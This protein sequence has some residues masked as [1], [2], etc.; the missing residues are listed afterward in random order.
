MKKNIIILMSTLICGTMFSQVGVNTPNPQGVFNVDG[1]KDNPL[2]GNGHTA[3]QQ[4]NDVTVLANGNVGLGTINPSAKLEV[5]TGGTASNPVP[6]FKLVD[7]T[8]AAGSILMSDANGVGTWQPYSI[9]KGVV[10][11]TIDGAG[12]TVKSTDAATAAPLPGRTAALYTMYQITLTKGS[13]I[14]NMGLTL[15]NT[16]YPVNIGAGTWVHGYISSDKTRWDVT[17]FTQ[18]GPAGGV[19]GYASTV[20]KNST[21]N[22]PNFFSGT[23]TVNVPQTITLYLLLEKINN[24]GGG[25]NG[26]IWEHNTARTGNYFYAI[27]SSN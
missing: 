5:Q 21:P 19:V 24:V 10:N 3:A 22:S 2:T 14:I 4:L 23:I 20:Y 26:A 6:G 9:A 8:Q 27:P 16:S 1:G 12:G 17:G 13:W 25:V 18:T 15:Y 11:G 7:G